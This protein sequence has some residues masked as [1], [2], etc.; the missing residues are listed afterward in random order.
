MNTFIKSAMMA[1]VATLAFG[2]AACDSKQENSA[3]DQAQSV[4]ESSDA[5]ADAIES[6]AAPV[7]GAAEASAD[8]KADA[9]REAGDAKADAMED[10]AD[11]MS[12][13]K[14]N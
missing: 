4:R 1:S 5:A 7:G 9:V 2:L 11:T 13:P 6:Q 8:A 12:S 14:S 10:K 3:E